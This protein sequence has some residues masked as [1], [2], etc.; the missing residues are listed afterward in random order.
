VIRS[1]EKG[2]TPWS[3]EREFHYSAPLFRDERKGLKPGGK[4]ITQPGHLKSQLRAT[5]YTT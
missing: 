5:S 1:N 2:K 4:G 3:L